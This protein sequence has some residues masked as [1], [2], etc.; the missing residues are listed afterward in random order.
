MGGRQAQLSNR[1][2]LK[3]RLDENVDIYSTILNC[4]LNG[5]FCM[6]TFY[7]EVTLKYQI[8]IYFK[9]VMIKTQLI[10]R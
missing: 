3:K 10:K 9:F 8:Y 6:K 5:I 4:L 1:S 2:F 7:R